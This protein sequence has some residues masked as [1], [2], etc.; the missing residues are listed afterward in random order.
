MFVYTKQNII[1]TIISDIICDKCGKKIQGKYA[2]LYK[3][4]DDGSEE[5]SVYCEQCYQQIIELNYHE[6][7]IKDYLE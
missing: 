6:P 4:N 3:E 1:T 5:F 2:T 7:E